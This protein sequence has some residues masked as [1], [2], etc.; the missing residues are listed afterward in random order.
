[1]NNTPVIPKVSKVL[2]LDTI[3]VKRLLGS[4]LGMATVVSSL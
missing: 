4:A 2:A 1:M 3:D